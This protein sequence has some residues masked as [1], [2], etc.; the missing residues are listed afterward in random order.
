[1]SLKAA[2]PTEI[3]RQFEE[4]H[5]AR[6]KDEVACGKCKTRVPASWCW[7]SSRDVGCP[8]SSHMYQACCSCWPLHLEKPQGHTTFLWELLGH[9]AGDQVP[10]NSW[11][12]LRS[13]STN[14]R[15]LQKCP[16]GTVTAPVLGRGQSGKMQ[17]ALFTES[18]PHGWR[19]SK[20]P[21]GLPEGFLGHRYSTTAF[22]V[23]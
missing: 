2:H 18:C 17:C 10:L 8:A 6:R 3:H 7:W 21:Q 14:Q 12:H 19:G 13:L 11:D 23:L 9:S 20:A 16:S 4:N 1:M 22:I 15:Q 5:S